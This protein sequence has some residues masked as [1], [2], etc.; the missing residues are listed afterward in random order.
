MDVIVVGAGPAGSAAAIV[1]ARAGVRVRLVDRAQFPR[2]K[3]CGDTLNPGALSIVD[4][5]GVRHRVEE[6]ALPIAGMTVSGPGGTQV[7]AA[8]PHGLRGCAIARRDLDD[9][10]LNAAIAA[11]VQFEPGVAARAPIV[12]ASGH[13]VEGVRVA[14]VCKARSAGGPASFSIAARVVIG[15]EGRHARLAF[16]LGLSRFVSSPKRWAFG[17]YFAGVSG[18]GDRGEMHIRGDG[19]IGIAPLPGG[20]ANVCVVRELGQLWRVQKDQPYGTDDCGV[21]PG[22][23]DPPVT[24]RQGVKPDLVIAGVIARDPALKERFASAQQVSPPVTLG[25]LGIES[26]AAGCPGLLLAGDAAGFID[27]MTGDGLRFALR[28]GELAADAALRELQSGV[29]AHAELAAARRREFS[30]KWRLNRALRLVVGSPRAVG[31]ATAVSTF[32]EAPIRFLIALAGDVPLA[33]DHRTATGR[34]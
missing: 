27:P 22:V 20:L 25:P 32:C 4:R 23:P 14:N 6:R 1:L 21:G 18:L 26:V 24:G 11:G 10:L 12:S 30:G 9:I 5:L 8:Y 31:L 16:A 3:L 34:R 28:G 29:P 17:A 2:D 15:A 19:Y 33:L 7:G 13:R